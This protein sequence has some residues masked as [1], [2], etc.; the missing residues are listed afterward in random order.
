MGHGRPPDQGPISRY[1]AQHR[2]LRVVRHDDRIIDEHAHRNDE[3]GQRSPVQPDIQPL[4]DQQRAS[5][6]EKQR[7]ADQQA[8]AES[9][10]RHDQQDHDRDRL[11]QVHD[12][13]A[14]R[15][16]GDPVLGIERLKRDTERHHRRDRRQLLLDQP[17]RTHDIL[18]RIGRNADAYS[19]LP[20]HAHQRRGR[21][22]VARLDPGDVAQADLKSLGGGQQLVPDVVETLIGSRFDDP[23]L[24]VAGQLLA[25]SDQRVLRA[26]NPDDLVG[27]DEQAGE[28]RHADPDVHHVLLLAE[29]RH[30]LHAVDRHQLG[31]DPLRPVAHLLVRETRIGRQTVV[32]A[33]HVAVIVPDRDRRG[34]LG[35][36]GLHGE[37]LPPKLVP[38]LRHF[39]GRSRGQQL[40]HDFRHAVERLGGD[41][42]DP[43]HRLNLALDRFGNQLLDLLGRSAGIAG[44]DRRALD[45]E[46][47]VF[48]LSEMAERDET[49]DEKHG[50][51]EPD[52]LRIVER[53]SRQIHLHLISGF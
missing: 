24:H 37:N 11:E 13:R 12:E 44:N 2:V 10:D 8:G 36:D 49:A 18:L 1:A 35:Q 6:S 27:R 31:L 28:R 4:H 17:A 41:F 19:P 22:R 21:L 40:D 7:A 33:E 42:I 25:A 46:R 3:P 5:D 20:V 29:K 47:R 30:F 34:P 43:A 15:L 39:V 51:K 9:H 50:Q 26:E 23:Y 38:H 52:H 14:V 32:D 48:L 16:G 53:V 45:H